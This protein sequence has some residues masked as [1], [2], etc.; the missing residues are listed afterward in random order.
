MCYSAMVAQHLKD[1]GLRFQ[2]RIDY[3]L[4]RD[5][6][7]RR[8]IGEK[9]KIPR[10]LDLN[11]SNPTFPEAIEIKT[12]IDKYKEQAIQELE[13]DLFAQKKRLA[14]AERKLAEKATKTA[15]K[16]KGIAERKIEAGKRRLEKLQSDS[17]RPEDSRIYAMDYAPIIVWEDGGRIIKPMRY[18]LR[19]AGMPES[20]DRDY[21]GCYNARRDSLKKFWKKQYRKN[22]A[23]LVISSFFENVQRDE[24]NLV[25]QFKPRGFEQMIVPCIWDRWTKEGQPD[26]YSFALITDDP[27][28]EV[29]Q[30]G[31]DRCPIFLKESNIDRWLR[32]DVTSEQEIE[33][34]LDDK[35]TPFYENSQVA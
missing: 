24:K 9:L 35:E 6:Y 17:A 4:M 32:P 1:L 13:T 11:F 19:S 12:Y 14:D 10:G 28:E 8:A 31:H 27:P 21:P 30:A 15:E 29:S 18:H 3:S 7:K 23:I 5:L 34:I 22:H 25:I 20:F 16:E 26:L 2:T 33:A